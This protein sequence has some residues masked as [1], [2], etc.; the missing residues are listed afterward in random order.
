[1][2][3]LFITIAS[4]PIV[5]VFVL[6]CVQRPNFASV[7]IQQIKNS[8]VVFIV[9]NLTIQILLAHKVEVQLEDNLGNP[10]EGA[11]FKVDKSKSLLLYPYFS[12]RGKATTDE[13]GKYST[14]LFPFQDL[15]LTA[16]KKGGYEFWWEGDEIPDLRFEYKDT[17]GL[18]QD[19][20][21]RICK[22]R[23]MG[24]TTYL[25]K[26]DYGFRAKDPIEGI[27]YD[28][29]KGRYYN[30][31][32]LS[33]RNPAIVDLA[34]DFNRNDVSETYTLRF[35][36]PQKAIKQPIVEPP[37]TS[38][39]LLSD[40]LLYEAPLSGYEKEVTMTFNPG[41]EV[42][43]YLYIASRNPAVFSRMK[44]EF[45]VNQEDLDL[46]AEIWTNPTA[47]GI[48]SMSRICLLI[49]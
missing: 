15:D 45:R 19:S 30:M 44:M 16:F 22:A 37:E 47:L 33:N 10:I 8:F 5:A 29:A 11:E 3:G 4:L 42:T 12:M 34:Y 1:M 28:L 38:G 49:C 9:F 27:A 6:L 24:G 7:S 18:F 41:D 46:D 20:I 31:N 48:W 35:Y 14:W 23:K 39:M 32:R 17:K 36:V 26:T 21:S 40:T 25:I 13:N 43:K 2:E